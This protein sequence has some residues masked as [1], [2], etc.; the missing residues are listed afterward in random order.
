MYFEDIDLCKN[1]KKMNYKSIYVPSV[2]MIHIGGKSYGKENNKITYEYRRSQLRY[3]DKHNS[4]LQ[5]I[6]VRLYIV[7]KFLPKMLDKSKN[8]LASDVLALVYKTH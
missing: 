2:K 8:K 3:Y 5:K 1:L 6:M 7:F 4:F